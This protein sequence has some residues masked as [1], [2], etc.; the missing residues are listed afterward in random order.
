MPFS[1]AH[2]LLRV[3]GVTVGWV[4][5]QGC[6]PASSS[7]SHPY[8]YRDDH[9]GHDARAPGRCKGLPR[10]GLS[11]RVARHRAPPHDLCDRIAQRRARSGLLTSS[12]PILA[13]RRRLD[14][15]CGERGGTCRRMDLFRPGPVHCRC[16][17]SSSRLRQ[18]PPLVGLLVARRGTFRSGGGPGLIWPHFRGGYGRRRVRQLRRGT[19]GE[20]GATRRRTAAA[21]GVA[22]TLRVWTDGAETGT[23]YFCRSPTGPKAPRR[24]F[25]SFF[26]HRT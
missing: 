21:H 8:A 3:C 18:R 19:R 17:L 16:H 22:S 1:V 6:R 7:E 5:R 13:T 20:H 9:R 2:I 14:R 12:W 11:F 10:R 25:A 4:G 23:R 24:R 15:I 26:R